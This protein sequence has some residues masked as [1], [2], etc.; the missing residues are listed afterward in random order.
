M[1]T[2]AVKILQSLSSASD[3]LQERCVA[4]EQLAMQ[5]G[6]SPCLLHSMEHYVL[7]RRGA[8]S[9]YLCLD[10]FLSQ[11]VLPKEPSATAEERGFY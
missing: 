1:V 8:L 7:E 4:R 9:L 11:S 3:T 10:I 5:Y 2:F 6:S